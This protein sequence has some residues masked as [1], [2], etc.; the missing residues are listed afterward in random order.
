MADGRVWGMKSFK[1]F[2]ELFW[3]ALQ[4]L[5]AVIIGFML[6]VSTIRFVLIPFMDLLFPVQ[7]G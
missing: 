5:I 1:E 3:F 6:A 7:H 4:I 2:W